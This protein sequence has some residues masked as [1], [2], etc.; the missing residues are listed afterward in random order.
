MQIVADYSDME[1]EIDRIASMPTAKMLV[2]LEELLLMDF[3]STNAATHVE[4]GSLK[5]SEKMI[6]SQHGDT[7]EGILSWGGASEGIHNPVDYAIYEYARG[8]AHDFLANATLSHSEWVHRIL[9]ELGNA[10]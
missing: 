9:G 6:S 4:T 5:S 10:K 1:R 2:I 7:W 8:G 3:V